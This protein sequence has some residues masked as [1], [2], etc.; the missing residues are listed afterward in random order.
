MFNE[1]PI[2]GLYRIKGSATVDNRGEF[3]RIFDAEQYEN[4]GLSNPIVQ[5]NYSI[6]H[7]KG[8]VRGM[9]YQNST[10]SEDKIVTCVKGKI[11]DVAIDLRKNSPTFLKWHGEI[12]DSSS[13]TGLFIPKG[14]AHGYQALC[15]NCEILYLHSNY[16]NKSHEGGINPLDPSIKIQ[17][18]L[19]ISELS[20]RDRLF[21]MIDSNFYGVS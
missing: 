6:N 20:D 1:T 3:Y 19:N 7:K 21:P 15:D 18:P 11:F 4:I 17:W 12:L 2:E 8:T 5:I 16:Y 10:Y 13:K 9:H 14:F